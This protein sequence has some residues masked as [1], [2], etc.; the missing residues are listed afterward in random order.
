MGYFFD[1]LP[2]EAGSR[3]TGVWTAGADLGTADELIATASLVR[4]GRLQHDVVESDFL[5]AHVPFHLGGFHGMGPDGW[6]WTVMLQLAP[7]S[8]AALVDA[9]PFWPMVDGLSR[10]L[11]LNGEATL[12][13]HHEITHDDVMDIYLDDGVQAWGIDEWNLR[14]L[15]LGL[16]AE[17]CYVPLQQIVLGRLTQCAFPGVV[18]DCQHDVFGDVFAMWASGQLVPEG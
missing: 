12:V 7:V 13:E 15:M 3:L 10:A 18:H 14:D 17:C 9:D 6:P 5:G 8:A 2:F 16:L 1:T 11:A 4:L